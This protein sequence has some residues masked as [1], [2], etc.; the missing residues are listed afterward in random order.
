MRCSATD[1]QAVKEQAKALGFDACGIAAAWPIDAE[2]RL[3]A[4][5]GAGYHAD[6]AWMARTQAV[7]QDIGL[8]LRGTRSVVVLA[9]NYYAPRA[10]RPAGAGLVSRYAWGGDYHRVLRGPLWELSRFIDALVPGS[11]SQAEVDAGPVLERAWAARAGLGWIGKNSLLIHPE[12]GSWVFLSVIATTA[13]LAADAPQKARCGG[14]T[15]CLGA[16]P[17]GAIVEPGLVD[18]RRCT[19]YHTIENRGAV[20]E[21]LQP[22]MGLWVFGCDTCQEVCPWNRNARTTSQGDFHPRAGMA[23]PDLAELAEIEEAEFEARFRDTAIRRA[24]CAGIRRNAQIALRNLAEGD[25]TR[26]AEKDGQQER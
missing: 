7:R 2:D 18:A 23:D 10:Q 3:G 21:D 4:W 1:A 15:A 16:C 19:A 9:S 24:K 17:A 22:C 13:A 6:M 5:L 11:R 14:C 25:L 8:W 20:P 12:F 26:G